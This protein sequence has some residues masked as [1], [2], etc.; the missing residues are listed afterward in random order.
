M[1]TI[2]AIKSRRSIRCFSS[3]P[4]E[5]EKLEQIRDVARYYPCPANLQSLKFVLL[6]DPSEI[7]PVF[8]HLRWAKYLPNYVLKEDSAPQVLFLILGDSTIASDFG[9]S[10]GAVA[11]EIMLAAQDLG[12][13]SCCLGAHQQDEILILLGIDPGRY[14]FQCLIA[15]G[16]GC[17][18]S[19]IVPYVN[20]CKY[21]LDIHGQLCVPKRSIT[22]IFLTP[23]LR[24]EKTDDIR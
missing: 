9:F 21:W 4:I 11:T 22:E 18:N 8:H 3:K 10:T 15:L 19:M 24:K 17:Q 6:E 7:L 23:C 12:I 13:S 1:N 16:Y 20:D 14:K 2:D 5:K